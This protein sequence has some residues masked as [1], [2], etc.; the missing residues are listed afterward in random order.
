MQ[1]RVVAKSEQYNGGELRWQDCRLVTAGVWITLIA[2]RLI[3]IVTA[4]HRAVLLAGAAGCRLA[5]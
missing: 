1:A 2:T 4:P 3:L 5:W